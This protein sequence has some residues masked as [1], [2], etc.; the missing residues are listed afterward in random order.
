MNKTM[1]IELEQPTAEAVYQVVK[2][3]PTAERLKLAGLLITNV[4]P[5]EIV[6]SSDYWT[7]EDLQDFSNASFALIDQRLEEEENAATR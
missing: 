4:S 5:R 7:E 6:D 1:T 3:F 2:A